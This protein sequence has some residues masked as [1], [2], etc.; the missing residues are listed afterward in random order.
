MNELLAE[1]LLVLLGN[2]SKLGTLTKFS[3]YQSWRKTYFSYLQNFE[4]RK[5]LKESFSKENNSS[6]RATNLKLAKR[7]MPIFC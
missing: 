3:V 5:L 4:D 1:A 7:P 6:F 2:S